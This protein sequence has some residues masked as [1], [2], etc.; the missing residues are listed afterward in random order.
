MM[1]SAPTIE[2]IVP[3][4]LTLRQAAEL[5]GVSER[6]LWNWARSGISPAP[7]KFGGSKQ[8]TVRYSRAAYMEW[9]AGDCKPVNGGKQVAEGGAA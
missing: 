4:L 7:I 5:C 8:N 2:T 1:N 6:T 3:E 9:L